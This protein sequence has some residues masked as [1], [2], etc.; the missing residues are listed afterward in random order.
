MNALTKTGLT[1]G[2]LLVSS[3]AKA[4]QSAVSMINELLRGELSAVETYQQAIKKVG[5]AEGSTDL[6]QM[7]SDHMDAV[8]KLQAEV[9]KEGGKPSTDSGA[10]GT[11]AKAV[12][13]SAKVL[14]DTAALKALKEGEQHG[15][16]EY[17]ELLE[18]KNTP[19][20]VKDL[21]RTTLLPKQQEHI[22]TLDRLMKMDSKS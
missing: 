21:V 9:M 2:L 6:Q 13:G 20:D 16:K 12:E 4:D 8:A 17:Q 14:G 10:W 22:Q 18:N 5:P 19:A 1:L 11:W 7:H 15:V 3:V